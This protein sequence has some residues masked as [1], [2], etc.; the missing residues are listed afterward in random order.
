MD[1]SDLFPGLEGRIGLDEV[2][3]RKRRHTAETGIVLFHVSS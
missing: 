1:G 2:L 3:E